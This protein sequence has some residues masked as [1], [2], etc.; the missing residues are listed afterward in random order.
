[1]EE[2]ISYRQGIS[3]AIGTIIDGYLDEKDCQTLYERWRSDWPEPLEFH[4]N[5]KAITA[6][7]ILN[8]PL[9]QFVAVYK[10]RLAKK[11]LEAA[12]RNV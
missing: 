11:L 6:S 12:Q 5:Q 2:N 1:M 10:K 9:K 7:M 3:Y 8:V 4:G